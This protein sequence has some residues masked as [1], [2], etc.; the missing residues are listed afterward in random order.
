ME[1]SRRMWS[2]NPALLA[3]N[4][5]ASKPSVQ[6]AGK[7]R[8]IDGLYEALEDS[9]RVTTRTEHGPPGRPPSI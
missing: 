8:I 1:T 9:L 2:L 5:S 3:M 4:S 6:N 7:G